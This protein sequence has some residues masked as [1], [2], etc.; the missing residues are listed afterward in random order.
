MHVLLRWTKCRETPRLVG[1]L[2]ARTGWEKECCE[3]VSGSLEGRAL[4]PLVGWVGGDRLGKVV[5]YVSVGGVVP[6]GAPLKVD[7]SAE[8]EAEGSAPVV[9]KGASAP[10]V[11]AKL[12][13]MK[14]VDAKQ[15]D[16]KLRDEHQRDAKLRDAKLR[17]AQLVVVGDVGMRLVALVVVRLVRGMI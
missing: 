7:S 5:F 1:V 3:R 10:P 6:S 9:Q 11:F 13:G 17:D 2:V 16:A 14:P 4:E 12:G 8:E 15:E